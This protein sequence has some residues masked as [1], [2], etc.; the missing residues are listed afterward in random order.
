MS[1][2]KEQLR[3]RIRLENRKLKRLQRQ[4]TSA[5]TW[6]DRLLT[7]VSTHHNKAEQA[8]IRALIDGGHRNPIAVTRPHSRG[9]RLLADAGIVVISEGFAVLSKKKDL[10]KLYS[11]G[12]TPRKGKFEPDN[13]SQACRAARSPR[14]SPEEEIQPHPVQQGCDSPHADQGRQNTGSIPSSL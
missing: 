7:H 2:Y 10:S 14:S 12:K 4:V 1:S 5:P 13:E 11:H 8:A 3:H 6:I 9:L